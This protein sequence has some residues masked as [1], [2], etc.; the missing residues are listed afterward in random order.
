[1]KEV[2]DVADDVL[3]YGCGD[4]IEVAE[5][6]PDRNLI[7]LLDRSRKSGIQWNSR[8]FA[9]HLQ[10]V[11][12]VGHKLSREGQP[13]PTKS[14]QSQASNERLRSLEI[15]GFANLSCQ[16]LPHLA[17]HAA[18]LRQLTVKVNL[19]TWQS[20][21]QK[22]FDSIRDLIARSTIAIPHVDTS[23]YSV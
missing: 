6:D 21:Q 7:A 22:A 11:T 17:D 20:Q 18:P 15:R 10:N 12:Y 1:M 5:K 9:F 23:S 16:V 14:P 2:T 4:S 8:K 3:V 13:D 19:W